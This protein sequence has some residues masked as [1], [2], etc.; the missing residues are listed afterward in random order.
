MVETPTL[1]EKYWCC[2]QLET[3]YSDFIEYEP[4]RPWQGVLRNEYVPHRQHL[5]VWHEVKYGDPAIET[6][7]YAEV[8]PGDLFLTQEDANEGYRIICREHAAELRRVADLW[9]LESNLTAAG[10][11]EPRINLGVSYENL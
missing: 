1:G 6:E 5:R 10:L 8:T 11:A 7:S 4:H 9:D 3:Q 2:K